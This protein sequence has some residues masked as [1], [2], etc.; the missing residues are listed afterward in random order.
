MGDCTCGPGA[1]WCARADALFD[2]PG[3]H[4]LD[5]G[6][7][8]DGRL[9]MRVESDQAATGCRS[10][11]VVAIGHGRR[12]HRLHD[13][14][15]FGTPTIVVWCKRVWRSPDPHCPVSTF[16]ETHDL[17]G[18]RAKLTTRA[19]GMGDRR[20]DPRRQHGVGAGPRSRGGL[21]HPGVDEHVWRPSRH[22]TGSTGRSPRWS[23]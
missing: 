12:E 18:P 10:C 7:D 22:G 11:G 13:A 2:V 14:P 9:V 19:I 6:R 23:T 5:F 16:S 15:C 8:E 1:R 17:V 20:A 3:M 21:A 4:V